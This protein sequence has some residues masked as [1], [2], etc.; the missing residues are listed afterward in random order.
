MFDEFA[1]WY[2]PSPPTPEDSIPII[3]E[4]VS[5]A[6][7]PQDEGDIGALEESPISFGLSG[8]DERLSWHDQ[9]DVETASSGDSVVHSPRNKP[10]RRLT[11]KEN[12]KK[13]M[14]EYDSERDESNRCESDS[15]K[16]EYG[17]SKAKSASAKKVSTSANEQLL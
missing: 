15:E 6:N 2:L 3:E 11:R 9:S 10:R 12:G 7:M 13:K 1:S 16:S 14:P 8:P 17:P 5:D 4:E